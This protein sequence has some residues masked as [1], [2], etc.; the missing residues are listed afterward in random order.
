[1]LLQYPLVGVLARPAS[2]PTS[3]HLKLKPK[4]G[5]VQ[6]ETPVADEAGE[7]V[8]DAAPSR[9]ELEGRSRPPESDLAIGLVSD[10]ALYVVP[11]DSVAAMRPSFSHLE[12]HEEPVRGRA[13]QLT[14]MSVQITRRE[15][16]AQIEARRRSYAYLASEEARE[17]WAEM[18]Y[19]E[20]E[21]EAASLLVERLKAVDRGSVPYP[22]STER[23][24]EAL[25]PRASR[26]GRL[27]EG[28]EDPEGEEGTG[29]RAGCV[30]GHAR[31]PLP[32][33]RRRLRA[34]LSPSD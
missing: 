12:K 20:S 26:T 1:M 6:L 27:G 18:R 16:E 24:L 32:P 7:A 22:M 21:S 33:T 28:E 13:Q 3:D 19:H 10:G 23:Y 4:H 29:K 9:L 31:S 5:R 14:Q 34:R 17:P 2:W 11:V 15:T 30:R 8:Q 25:L